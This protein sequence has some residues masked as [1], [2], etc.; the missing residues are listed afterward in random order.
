MDKM[1]RKANPFE[2][3]NH[4]VLAMS[5]IVLAIQGYAFL[6]H[7]GEIGAFFG[8]FESMRMIHNYLGIAFSISLFFTI[9]F[10]LK[11]S[12][13]FDADDIGWIKIAGGYLSHSAKVPPMGKLNTG[14][15]FYYLALLVFGIGISVSGYVFWLAADNKQWVLYA[16]LIHNI[17]F[18]F[19]MIAVPV[20]MYLG[21]LAN[22]GTFRIMVYGTVPY[23]WAK[24]KHPKWIGDMGSHQ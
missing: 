17:S 21:S 18:V 19:V 2:I 23:W 6:F 22:P 24:K 1:V 16:H 15:K 12:L 14:Q 11:E 7:M 4:W 13:A 8:G 3:L 10:Y 5:C 9:F 20:H